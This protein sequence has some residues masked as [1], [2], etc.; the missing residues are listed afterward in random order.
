MTGPTKPTPQEYSEARIKYAQSAECLEA[1]AKAERFGKALGIHDQNF[2]MFG[3]VRTI[4]GQIMNEN[5][6]I[7]EA[8]HK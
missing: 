2:Q 1:I 6:A 3:G 7:L 8:Y 5:L 4:A